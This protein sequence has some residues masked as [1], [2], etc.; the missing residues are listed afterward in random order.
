MDEKLRA[1]IQ[2]AEMICAKENEE[3]GERY[4]EEMGE[5][6]TTL[7]E[8]LATLDKDGRDTRRKKN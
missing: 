6:A 1:F 8:R 4:L 7:N 3:Y 2:E 5:L